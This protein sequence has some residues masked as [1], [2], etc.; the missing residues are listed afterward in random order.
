[1]KPLLE[2]LTPPG[3][4]AA[5][6]LMLA[7]GLLVQLIACANVANLLLA[8]ATA[9]RQETALRLALGAGK[10]RILRHSLTEG[11]LLS[12]AGG[13]LGLLLAAWGVNGLTGSTPVRPPFW[14]VFDLDGRSFAFAA[15]VTALSAL[16]VSL[17]P[18]W[19]ARKADVLGALKDGARS[20]AGGPQG[21]LGRALVVTE[22][23]FSLVLLIGAA[24]LVQSFRHRY[25]ADSGLDT[26]GA[27]TARLTLSGETYA[28]PARRATL[29]EELLRRLRARPDV[30]EAGAANGLPFPDPLGGTGE[31]RTFEVE[32]Q[33]TERGHEPSTLYC[34]AATG[35]LQAI[36]LPLVDGRL[37]SDEEEAEGRDVVVVSDGMARRLWGGASAVG[38]RLRLDGG[39]WLEVV[40]LVR[41]LTDS[42]DIL[43]T[44]GRPAGQIYV[45]YRREPVATV[46]LVVRTRTEPALFAG[47]LRDE[48]RALEPTV[49]LE[50]VFSL[51]EVRLRALWVS[52][53]WGRM[54]SVIAGLA[55]VLA[56]LGVYG[57]VSYTVAQRTQEIGVRMAVGA[58]PSQVLRLVLGQGLGLALRALAVGL[59]GAF[60]LARALSGLLFGIDPLDPVTFAGGA[61]LLGLTA[62]LASYLPARRA[63]RVDPL[64]A[65]RAS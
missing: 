5:L 57:V 34:T 47:A 37:F 39:P 59:L 11:L 49:P 32:G 62:I 38:R 8:K 17:A 21:R 56:A 41:E 26:K 7:A 60:G 14:V 2:W 3:V 43:W 10:G 45:P 35:Y 9:Q 61:L 65:L 24:L 29:L 63:T 28:D 13:G 25:D 23:G 53:I 40:G 27:L 46:S 15:G 54:L 19:Q 33:P 12:L 6:R 36:G 18:V 1:M 20:V 50:S 30:V 4:A 42:G 52:Q 55:L 16:L 64:G 48:L 31:T 51:D 44:G 22:L 58:R